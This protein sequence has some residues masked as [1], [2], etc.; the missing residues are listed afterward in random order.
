VKTVL[1]SIVYNAASIWIVSL[2]ASGIVLEK[3]YE[4]L[5]VAAFALGLIN[6]LVKPVINILLLPLNLI[7][8]GAFRWL[9]NVLAL[10]LVT[11]VVP[12]FKIV[13]V[14]F[15]GFTY[16]GIIIPPISLNLIFSFVVVSFLIS[17]ISSFWY[18]LRR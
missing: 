5:L 1:R 9:V 2:L 7:T 15:S 18:W 4:T 8:L 11:V 17:F 6:L 13:P 3:G 12:D 14:H 10:Y 16:R